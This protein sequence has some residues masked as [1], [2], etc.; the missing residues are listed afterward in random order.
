MRTQRAEVGVRGKSD[1]GIWLCLLL[2]PI[3]EKELSEVGKL[4]M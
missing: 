2:L 3:K 1:V 4:A